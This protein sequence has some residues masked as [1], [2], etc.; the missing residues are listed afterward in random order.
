[1]SGLV[2]AK[3]YDWKDS[4]LALFGSDTEKNVSSREG[5]GFCRILLRPW[6][7]CTSAGEEV[8]C[9]DRAGLEWCGAEGRN[10]DL[11]NCQVQGLCVRY[12]VRAA[13]V[14]GNFRSAFR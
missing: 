3:K 4:N 8:F 11:E 13:L 6:C 5:F 1:M 9:R 10:P 7:Y 2:K 12:S 14:A